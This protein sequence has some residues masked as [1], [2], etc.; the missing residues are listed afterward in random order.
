MSVVR[1]ELSDGVATITLDRPEALNALTVELKVALLEA[2]RRAGADEGARAVL[3]TGAGRAFCV[4]QDLKEHV[5]ALDAGDTDLSTVTDHYNPLIEAIAGLPKP[6]VAAVNGPAAGAGASLAFAC[7]IR[8]AGDDASFLMAFAKVGLGPDSGASWTLPRLIGT[9]RAAAM[10]MLAEPV[11]AAEALELGLV[12]MIVPAADLVGTATALAARLAAGPTAA[13]AAIKET[14][15]F[16]ASQP[17]VES[18]A[19]EARAQAR[20]GQTADHRNAVTA[21]LEKRPATFTGH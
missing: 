8:I 14:I 10:L 21:F 5:E 18:L 16:S 19:N 15:A 4:G 3:L 13:Y 7:D 6:V 17:L 11:A 12:S 20:C 9:G 2:V 1:Y